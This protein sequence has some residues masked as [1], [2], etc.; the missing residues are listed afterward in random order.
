MLARGARERDIPQASTARSVLFWAP[1]R[2]RAIQDHDARYTDISDRVWPRVA[3]CRQHGARVSSAIRKLSWNAVVSRF[4]SDVFLLQ[5]TTMQITMTFRDMRPSPALQAAAERWVAR[6]EQVFDRIAGC[7][8]SIEKPHR[9]HL[10]GSLVLVNI[11]LLVPGTHIAVSN[12]PNE[13]AYVA[14]AD[15]FRAA[16]RKLL[17]YVDLHRDFV[18]PPAGGRYSGLV[19]DKA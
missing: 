7:H 3:A 17:E 13:D 10:H 18:V 19:P 1:G 12:Q 4:W 5:G 14:L 15:A 9:H 11:L 2:W 8:V 16:R 6:L